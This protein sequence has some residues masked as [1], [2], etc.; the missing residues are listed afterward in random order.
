MNM[1]LMNHNYTS[2]VGSN[3]GSLKLKDSFYGTWGL[4]ADGTDGVL[5]RNGTCNYSVTW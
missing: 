5:P 1:P 2:L 4:D 3:N